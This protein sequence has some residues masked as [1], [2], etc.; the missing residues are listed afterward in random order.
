MPTPTTPH[1]SPARPTPVVSPRYALYFAPHPTSAWWQA[2]SAW[3]GRCAATGLAMPQPGVP[4][5]APN[6][7]A[8]LTAAP[9]RYGWHATLK[10]PFTLG[11]GVCVADVEQRLAEVCTAFP[12]FTLPPLTVAQ[13]GHFL[14]LVPAGPSEHLQRVADACVA[15]LHPLAAPLPPT[16]LQRRRGN[17]LPAAQEALLQAW[18]YPHVFT[19]FRFHCSLTGHLGGVSPTVVEAVASAARAWFGV[20]PPCRFEAVSLFEEPGP[21]QPMRMVSQ[22]PLSAP[23][24]QP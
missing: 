16:E 3:L 23:G 12:A 8:Q 9:A 1:T 22:W 17:G 13:L 19:H 6:Q 24:V 2:G 4:G 11:P 14:A 7:L 18:G 5:V 10:A 15:D 21:G 20:L